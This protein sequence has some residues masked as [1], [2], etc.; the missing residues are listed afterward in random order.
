MT[1]NE[2]QYIK[3]LLRKALNALNEKNFSKGK[4]LLNKIFS[5]NPNI[6][7]VNYNLAVL[8]AMDN[9]FTDSIKF[10]KNAINLKKDSAEVYFN[11]AMVYQKN[12]QL[13][14]AIENFKKAIEL[15]NNNE[16]TNYNIGALYK[17]KFDNINAEKYFQKSISINVK[18]ELGLSA[19][20]DLYDKSNDLKKFENLLKKIIE[21]GLDDNFIS[22]FSG[23][24]EF[25]KKNYNQAIKNL[26]NLNLGQKNIE[27]NIVK[28]GILAK[29]YDHVGKYEE[30]Y[31][32]FV[33][34]NNL[35]NEGY[36]KNI[37]KNIFLNYVKQ[38]INFFKN[39]KQLDWKGPI[40][41]REDYKEP[42]FLI[43]FPRSGTTL[44]D[45]IL[46]TKHSIEV[47]EEKPIVRNF[48]IKLEKKTKNDFNL[49]KNLD[50]DFIEEMR[51][52]YFQERNKYLEKNDAKI[53]VDK[54][55]LNIIHVGEILRFFPKAKFI[56]ALRHPYDSV[57]SCFMQQFSLN[58]AMKNF[59]TLES[60]A[61]LYDL[62][63]QLW[64]VYH[65][66]FKIN[67]HIIKYENIIENFDQTV[68]DVL[69][70]FSV[71]WSSDYKDFYKI[72]QKRN[73][74]MTPSYSQVTSPIYK[75]SLNRWKNYQNKFEKSKTYLDKWI[76]EFNYK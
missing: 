30:A 51:K 3:N 9:N 56:L 14:L 75:S 70:F 76:R 1:I 54:M 53:V 50:N 39:N 67:L 23:I 13:D 60:S 22:Y 68:K 35:M 6:F 48:L 43:G 66:N 44:L 73:N 27:K 69:N 2:T 18:F 28:C 21:D 41:I 5:I 16:I 12:S 52:F 29:S 63:M 10:Y 20:F 65:E 59:L 15:G 4:K 32:S 62:V 36:G 57:F 34:A 38:R 8:N 42:A 11:L 58:P 72:A 26:V 47:I 40:K 71:D 25:K 24:N 33:D 74:I 7:D 37:D 55:P 61:F 45:T 64:K 31:N 46:R 19:L 49:L 17:A